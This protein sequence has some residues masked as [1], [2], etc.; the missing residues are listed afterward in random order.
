M[1]KG[2]E[3]CVAIICYTSLCFAL[4]RAQDA[5]LMGKRQIPSQTNQKSRSRRR[6]TKAKSILQRLARM[7]SSRVA[8]RVRQKL[9]TTTTAS[10][11][12][13]RHLLPHHRTSLLLSSRP[14]AL[15]YFANPPHMNPLIP[16]Q[17][18]VKTRAKHISLPH[19]NNIPLLT[20]IPR[21][22]ALLIQRSRPP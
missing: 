12:G 7:N 14:H 22:H 1:G 3:T 9:S 17:F 16:R 18:R 6:I 20:Y 10:R 2:L 13:Q 8:S 4:L 15:H 11:Y 5:A 21:Q 19:C